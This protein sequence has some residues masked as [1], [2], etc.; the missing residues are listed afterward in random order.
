MDCTST[1]SEIYVNGFYYSSTENWTV[2][3]TDDWNTEFTS[4]KYDFIF[5]V[6]TVQITRNLR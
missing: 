3:K 1:D 2:L 5:V 6:D 4:T